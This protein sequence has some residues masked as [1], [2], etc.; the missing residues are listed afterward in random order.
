MAGVGH[1]RD[2]AGMDERGGVRL[3]DH[4]W[5]FDAAPAGSDGRQTMRV[6]NGLAASVKI[7]SRHWSATGGSGVHFSDSQRSASVSARAAV[8]TSRTLTISSVSSGAAWP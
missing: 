5:A 2:I 4:R 1:G 6:R 7:T 8:T 3:L